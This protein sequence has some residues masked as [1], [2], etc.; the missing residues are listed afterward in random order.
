[1]LNG[2]VD[3]RDTDSESIAL[4]ESDRAVFIRGNWVRLGPRQGVILRA[5]MKTPG[6]VVTYAKLASMVWGRPVAPGLINVHIHY[7]RKKLELDQ[8]RPRILLTLPGAGF[9]VRPTAAELD[10][11]LTVLV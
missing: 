10:G 3:V 8:E 2:S 5:L 1:M 7:L 6:Q 4:H 9:V 11:A